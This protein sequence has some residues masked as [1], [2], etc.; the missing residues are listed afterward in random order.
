MGGMGICLSAMLLG[1]GMGIAAE[2]P[3]SGPDGGYLTPAMQPDG[4]QYLPPPPQP[5]TARQH[6]DDRAFTSTRALK[7]TPR[8]ALATSDADLHEDALLHAFSCAAGQNLSTAATPHLAALIHTMD[9]S[10]APDMRKSKAYWH[11]PRP[12]VGNGQPI[13]TEDDRAHLATSGA[14]PSGHTMLGWSI[15]LVLAELLPDR[16][17]PILQ[18]GRV[19]G[20]SRIV[21]GVH[22]ES[23]V[24]AGYMVGAAEIAAM[25]GSPAFRADMEQARSELTARRRDA[26]GSQDPA[27]AIESDAA[28]HS[29]L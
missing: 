13:C 15:A 28:R 4:T 29:P 22:W 21:C 7:G 24:Q 16:A 12:F 26:V 20:E 8:W 6:T 10:E 9:M 18:R 23:D 27:C 25:H 14:Y 5:G 2:P 11:R 19:F 3:A 17:T 1:G